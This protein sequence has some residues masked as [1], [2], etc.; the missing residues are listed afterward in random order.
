MKSPTS[1]PPQARIPAGVAV[2]GR[3]KPSERREVVVERCEACGTEMY[4][5]HCKL[6]CPN[7]GYKRDCSDP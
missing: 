2:G 1:G 5:L 3:E 6:V 4:G 7:C